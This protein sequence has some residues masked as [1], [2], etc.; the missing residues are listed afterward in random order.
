MNEIAEKDF[1][2]E[3]ETGSV[4]VD[5]FGEGC[6]NCKLTEPTLNALSTENPNIKFIKIDSGKA[7]K[8]TEKFNISALPTILFIKDGTVKETLVGL[9][10]RGVLAR[11]IANEL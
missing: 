2:N 11:T 9:K 7:P 1:E 3:T 10:P 8:L 6:I 4:I 5:F